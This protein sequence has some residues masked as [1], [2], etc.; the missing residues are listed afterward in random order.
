MS[1]FESKPNFSAINTE[2]VESVGEQR[3]ALKNLAWQ[4][5]DSLSEERAKDLL[6]DITIIEE[7][8]LGEKSEP[9]KHFHH[10]TGQRFSTAYNKAYQSIQHRKQYKKKIGKDGEEEPLYSKVRFVFR[11]GLKGVIGGMINTMPFARV[12][13]IQ[14]DPSE[15]INF[16]KKDNSNDQ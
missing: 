11:E 16:L 5:V 8:V 6:K 4:A 15:L 14:A 3:M 9:E 1:D 10:L 12:K 13:Q 2:T 7:I